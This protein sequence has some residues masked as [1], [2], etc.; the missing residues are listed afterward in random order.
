[1]KLVKGEILEL[2]IK[3]INREAFVQYGYLAKGYDFSEL[4]R[5]L[6]NSTEKPERGVIYTPRDG[7][8]EKLPVAVSIRDSIFGG[9][10]VQIGYCNGS[11]ITLNSLE[12][13]RGSELIIAAD[14]IILLIAPLQKMR[15]FT[16]D[17]SEVEA[18]L[19]PAGC[20]ALLYETTLHY[21]PC[22]APGNDGFRTIVV[23]P[24]ATNTEKPNITYN[25]DE[26]KLLWARNKWLVAHPDSP[27]AKQGAFVGLTGA[28]I[29]L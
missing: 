22:N 5:V 4:L 17:T 20:A 12:Y 1:M 6:E 23:L 14:D 13:H 18:F 2:E 25:C 10:P 26:D 28:N 19:L 11:N 29:T 7:N 8:L 24:E 27:E 21:A 15:G 16:L 3:S 9:M